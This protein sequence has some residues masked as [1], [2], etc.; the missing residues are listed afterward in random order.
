MEIDSRSLKVFCAVADAGSVQAAASRVALS[1]SAVSR[2]VSG[3]EADLGLR[4]FDR[5]ERRMMPTEAGRAFHARAREAVLLF[6]DLAAFGRARAGRERAPLRIAGLSRHAQTI[7]TPAVLKLL[8]ETPEPGPVQLDMHAQRDFGFSRL[9]RPFDVGIGNLVAPSEEY[10]SVTIARSRLIACMAPG[11][12]LAGH[13]RLAATAIARQP[14]IAL[15][16]DTIIGSIV[17]QAFGKAEAPRIVAEVS[18]TYLALDL[19]AS[20]IGIHVTDELAALDA[21]DRGAVLLP[22]EDVQALDV[23]A[24]W[25]RRAIVAPRVEAFL[26]AVRS[27]LHARCPDAVC[28]PENQGL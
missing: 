6:D 4:L 13:G 19:A 8:G 24:F 28:A 22:V 14:L 23:L 15:S 12:P 27:V 21:R 9:A 2:I 11:H 5:A 18:H 3:L 20:G 26:G 25:P 1:P 7:V 10:Q 16:R 17:R